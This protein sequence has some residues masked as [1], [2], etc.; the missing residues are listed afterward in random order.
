[1]SDSNN[2]EAIEVVEVV[3]AT[4]QKSHVIATQSIDSVSKK[5]WLL[6][7]FLVLLILAVYVIFLLPRVVDKNKSGS[8]DAQ[9][10]VEVEQAQVDKP[11]SIVAQSQT[12]E[13]KSIE[14]ESDETQQQTKLQ[15]E[16]L[17]TKI[18]GLESELE[19]HAVKKW[20]AEEFAEAIERGRV[21][22]EYFRQQQYRQ[23][24]ESFQAAIDK[25]ESLQQHIQ[26]TFDRAIT[27]GEQALTLGDQPAA[28]QQFEL[29][30]AIFPKDTSAINGLQR[31]TTL[32]QLFSL[33]QR[34]SSFEFHNQLQQAKSVYQEAVTLDSLSAEAK[35]A[36]A[37]VD[38]KLKGEAFDQTIA[39]AYQALQNGQYADARS[40]FNDAKKLKPNSN[41]P[42]VGLKKV[43]AAIRKEKIANLL[44]E[45]EHFVQLEQWSQSAISYE[46]VLK[47]N[48]NHQQAK[49]GLQDSRTKVEILD[50]L[51][52]A[53]AKADQLYKPA[54]LDSAEQVLESVSKLE[55]P[56][57]TIEQQYKQLHQL[58]R[59][60]STPIPVL[61]VSDNNTD[62]TVFKVKR[63]G[64]INRAELQ[65]RPGPYTIVGSRNGFRDVRKT[66]RV[67]PDS[68]NSTIS[69]ICEEPI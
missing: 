3:A 56:G 17:L 35:T 68:E 54:A 59:T 63:L 45:A 47:I 30:K 4:A 36:L 11:E 6:I 16:E 38:K 25:F 57:S 46:K 42:N 8:N 67:T 44:F 41:E 32:E 7:S 64:K 29:A 49:S 20:A 40:G 14:V 26:P 37:R 55:F 31:A 34:G 28:L 22:D 9:L 19:K 52:E 58:V 66:I 10:V 39:I 43:A 61:L 1:M 21:G 5:K 12:D 51:K 33:L 23:A 69:I 65:L 53:L 15:A 18:I 24:A 62:I 50:Q 60:A 27:R 13:S 2:K 48:K